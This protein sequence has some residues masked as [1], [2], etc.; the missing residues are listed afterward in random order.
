MEDQKK[1][2]PLF[3][4]P[5]VQS[6]SLSVLVFSMLGVFLYWQSTKN[7]VFIENSVLEA[8]S[9]SIAPATGGTLNALYV[10][11]GD[12]VTAHTNVALVGS[13]ILNTQSDGIVQNAPKVF[14]SYIVPGQTVV[15]IINNKEMRVV[16]AIDET[17]GLA[18]IVKGQYASFTVDA[19]PGKKYEG[20]VDEV[21]PTSVNTG[22]IFSISDKR[23]INKFNV[24]IRFNVANYP[25]LKSGMS[26]KITVYTK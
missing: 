11:E 10:A 14:G 12:I 3:K 15:S 9:I 16:G 4:K 18:T 2:E 21:S 5:W 26:A 7:T 13:S 1:K 19:F 23:P 24:K 25:E 6:V 20:I 8:P 22:I 17:K